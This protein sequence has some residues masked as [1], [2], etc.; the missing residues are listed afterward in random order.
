MY[1]DLVRQAE[2][3]IAL[4]EELFEGSG[5]PEVPDLERV[6]EVLAEVREGWYGG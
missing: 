6:E 1:D 5:L 2:E 4:I 3:K